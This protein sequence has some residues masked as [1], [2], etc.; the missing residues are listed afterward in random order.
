MAFYLWRAAWGEGTVVGLEA[1]RSVSLNPGLRFQN[2]GLA[3]PL[4]F[5]IV[6]LKKILDVRYLTRR[7]LTKV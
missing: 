3:G 6:S 7:L 4:D 5:E 1:K 2:C